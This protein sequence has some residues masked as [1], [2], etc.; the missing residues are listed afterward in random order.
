[1]IDLIQPKEVEIDGKTYIIS[2]FPAMAGREILTQMP[3]TAAAATLG[4]FIKGGDYK[5]NEDIT[6]KVLNYV[7]VKL[8]NGTTQRLISQNLINI[9]VTSEYPGET[10]LKIEDEII[11]Y[12]CSFFKGGRVSTF[13][14]DI[15]LK[16]PAWTS[17]M[18]TVF[19]EQS[20]Q[21]E[22]PH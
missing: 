10:L 5:L 2:K 9:Y 18:L 21:K 8:D 22:K 15:A 7:A 4:H 20:S 17:R 14:R 13:L 19:L 6:L 3:S 16:L 11:G 12:N 1:M